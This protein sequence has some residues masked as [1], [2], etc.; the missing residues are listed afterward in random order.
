MHVLFSR[1]NQYNDGEG[2]W[3]RTVRPCG[4][5]RWITRQESMLTMV[6][7]WSAQHCVHARMV[8]HADSMSI[9]FDHHRDY[10]MWTM[11][12]PGWVMQY[13]T[14]VH[15]TCTPLWLEWSMVDVH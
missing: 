9:Y 2:P 1:I 3:V 4:N 10:T 14:A 6:M 5:P 15:A 8:H 7:A 13:R 12:W 11:S